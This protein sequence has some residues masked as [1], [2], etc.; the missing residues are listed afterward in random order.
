MK[1][2]EIIQGMSEDKTKKKFKDW[3]LEFPLI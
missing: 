2:D 1:S 3:V